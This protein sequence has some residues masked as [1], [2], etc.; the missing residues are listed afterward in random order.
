MDLKEYLNTNQIKKTAFAK[1]LGITPQYLHRI[2]NGLKPSQKLFNKIKDITRGDTMQQE[3]LGLQ[4]QVKT[5]T[6]ALEDLILSIDRDFYVFWNLTISHHSYEHFYER[7]SIA[8]L[9]KELGEKE[10]S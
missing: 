4:N 10:K 3:L 6:E 7:S 1:R 2:L 9:V 8:I 5:L